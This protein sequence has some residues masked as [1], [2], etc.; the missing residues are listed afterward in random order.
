MVA[1]YNDLLEGTNREYILHEFERFA[2]L[3]KMCGLRSHP[4]SSNSVAIASLMYP[5]QIAWF[6]DNGAFPRSNYDNQI[7]KI[8]WLNQKIHLLNMENRVPLYPRF[9]TY[10][11]RTAT[12][13]RTDEFGE[14][15]PE[16]EYCASAA[17]M[18]AEEILQ[19]AEGFV[20]VPMNLLVQLKICGRNI[21]NG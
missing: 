14:L 4:D 1:G 13:Y 16:M 15:H 17:S 6:P 20:E 9:H 11:V 10:G 12:R 3:V 18:L 19:I 2:D 8:D 5:P 7:H 21:P